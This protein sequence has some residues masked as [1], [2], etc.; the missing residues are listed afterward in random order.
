MALAL[1]TLF[2]RTELNQNTTTE[3]GLYTGALFFGVVMIMFNGSADL[4][5]TIVRLPVFYKQRDLLLFPTWTYTL[6]T[7]ITKIPVTFVEVGLW[8]SLTYY[9]IGFDPN[10]GR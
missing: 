3:G 5:M 6:L 2:L 8:V 7:W 1:M 9:V 4:A 10:I